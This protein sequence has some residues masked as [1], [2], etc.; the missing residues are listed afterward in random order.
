MREFLPLKLCSAFLSFFLLLLFIFQRNTPAQNITIQGNVSTS[1]GNV[2]NAMVTYTDKNDASKF[3]SALTDISGNYF[4]NI[5]VTSVTEN[6]G[7]PASFSLEQNYPNPF[8]NSTAIPYDLNTQ[9]D[10]HITIYDILGRV[11]RKIPLG[12]QTAGSHVIQWDGSNS[13]GKRVSAGVYLYRLEAGGESKVRKMIFNAGTGGMALPQMSYTRQAPASG[14]TIAGSSANGF[15]V[16]IENTGNTSPQIINSQLDA[17]IYADTIINFTVEEL[18]A[19]SAIVYMDSIQ[20]IIRGFGAANIMQWRPDMTDDNIEKAFGTSDGQIGFSLLRLRL[21]SSESEFIYQVPTAQKAVAKGVTV[22]A[23]PWSPPATLKSNNNIVGGYLPESSYAAYASHLKSFVDYMSSNRVPLYAVSIQNEPD[24]N[25]DYESCDWYDYEMVNFIKGYGAS[26]GTKI[27]A[28]ESFNFNKTISNAILNDPEAATN[29]DIV[30]GHLYGG[31]LEAY[32][33][34]ASKGKEL[35]MTEYLNL[36]TTWTEALATGKQINDCMHVGMNAYIWWYIVR[37]YGPIHED[38]RVTR[39]GYVMSHYARFIRPG[40]YKIKTSPNP[41]RNVFL[42][43]YKDDTASKLVIVAINTSTTAAIN[44]NISVIGK[45]ITV[46]TP[47]TSSERKNCQQGADINISNNFF[48]V[49][50]EPSSI[51]TFISK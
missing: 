45:D 13:F 8:S 23:S 28:P 15:T 25:V 33:L 21:P 47:Y 20:Q 41:Q 48:T 36:D 6:T 18:P 51:T 3:Y 34:A 37:F 9:S 4:I 40:Y 5:D 16:K 7:I 17:D 35:W 1:S 31:G 46:F 24:I 49:T 29:L 44:Q 30:G 22:F 11:V 38:G 10:V 42:T 27:I 39:R 2:Q 14:K 26:I 12:Q 32:S 19:N 50:L 43:S